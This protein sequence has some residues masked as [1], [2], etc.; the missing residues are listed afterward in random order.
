MADEPNPGPAD[1]GPA[2]DAGAAPSP[3][4][5]APD[6][7]APSI[8][9]GIKPAEP[10]VFDA[11]KLKLPE[12]FKADDPV[13]KQFGEIA[14]KAKIAP[15]SAQKLFDLYTSE[16]KK[17]SESAHD[18]FRQLNQQW[19][20]EVKGDP[21]IGGD[22]LPAVL[23]TVSKAFDVYGAPGVKE[24]LTLTGAGN[25]PAIVKTFYKMARALT[26]GGHVG[27]KPASEPRDLAS[28]MYPKGT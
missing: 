22:K 24:A 21:E 19:Q 2:P 11:A 12:G 26:E 1:P 17:V 5:P 27:G 23:Q 13:F 10:A 25:N 7:S 6:Q 8:L 28:L 16:V 3:A 20:N 4:A 18:G 14:T 9:E 15:E